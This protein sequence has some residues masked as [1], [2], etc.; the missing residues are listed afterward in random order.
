MWAGLAI[1]H[2]SHR[3]WL[4]IIKSSVQNRG[5]GSQYLRQSSRVYQN[6]K[7]I[8]VLLL[9]RL[10]IRIFTSNMNS[11]FQF[12]QYLG[13]TNVMKWSLPK[14]WFVHR[15]STAYTLHPSYGSSRWYCIRNWE[16][17]WIEEWPHQ[18]Q[19]RRGYYMHLTVFTIRNSILWRTTQREGGALAHPCSGTGPRCTW[20]S[21]KGQINIFNFSAYTIVQIHCRCEGKFQ[22]VSRQNPA[23]FNFELLRL[24]LKFLNNPKTMN[25]RTTKVSISKDIGTYQKYWVD[26]YWYF[27]VKKCIPKTV[28]RFSRTCPS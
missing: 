21:W 24:H 25:T 14:P 5:K 23:L 19:L 27:S 10:S 17:R 22:A 6:F 16:S 12:V 28:I 9:C 15:M 18:F 13:S 4:E 8:L 26:F 7:M 20:D 11:E 1:S 3:C 2:F